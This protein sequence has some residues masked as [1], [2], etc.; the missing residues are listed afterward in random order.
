MP[1][2]I[3]ETFPARNVILKMGS[4]FSRLYHSIVAFRAFLKMSGFV[5]NINNAICAGNI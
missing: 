1:N 5:F 2:P 4:S 3:E